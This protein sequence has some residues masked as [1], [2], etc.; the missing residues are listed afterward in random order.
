M[1]TKIKQASEIIKKSKY[2]VAFTGA[3]ISVESN[4]PTFRGENGI[5]NKYDPKTLD[6]DYF[7]TN[8]EICWKQITDMFF[9]VIDEAK[10]NY[11]H[12]FLAKL[13][14]EKNLKTIITQ[15]IDN[16][17][18]DAGNKNVVEYHGNTRDLVCLKCDK[19]YKVSEFNL[20]KEIP[21]CTCGNI[22]KPDFVFFGEGIPIDA[23]LATK[24]MLEKVDVML[25]IGTTGE[26]LPASL[27]PY[28]AKKNNAVIIEINTN[29]SNYTDTVT[30]IFLQGKATEICKLL[31]KELF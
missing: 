4:I 13:E 24:E 11:A 27:I 7:K 6:I 29:K 26:I 17:H 25:I 14:Q 1:N 22:L 21:K 5:W 20:K 3:G 18:F 12:Y 23:T 30:D 9:S 2:L 16:L 8:P 31:D 28:E 10:P 15:N 19:R